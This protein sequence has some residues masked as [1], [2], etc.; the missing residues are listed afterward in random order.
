[1]Q[2]KQLNAPQINNCASACKTFDIAFVLRQIWQLQP[3]RDNNSPRQLIHGRT[4][5][6]QR[7]LML[8]T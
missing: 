3:G 6:R 8:F 2:D 7:H 1:M 5:L 4:N